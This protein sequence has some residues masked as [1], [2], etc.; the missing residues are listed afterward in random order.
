PAEP[1][2]AAAT[3]IFRT[4]MSRS[5]RKPNEHAQPAWSEDFVERYLGGQLPIRPRTAK[6]SV[7]FR[8]LAPPGLLRARVPLRSG[9]LSVRVRA[10]LA[11]QRR[12]GIATNFVAHN[13]FFAGAVTGSDSDPR[14]MTE[15]RRLYVQTLVNSDY[16]LC[17][18][19]AGNFSYRL[20]ETLSV[21]RI[22]VFVDTDCVL[23]FDFHLRWR[24]YCVWVDESE[25][26]R[27]GDRVLEFHERLSDSEFEDLQREC[28]LLW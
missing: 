6:P 20:Y 1:V 4:S 8:G 27:I 24:D 5:T 22:P 2:E 28:R 16:G 9:E 23:P 12:H 19:G 13:A 21:G 11:L 10:M 15:A 17:A 14:A 7:G 3:V 18:R 25:L 26:D